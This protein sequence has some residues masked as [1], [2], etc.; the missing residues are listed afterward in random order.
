MSRTALY[1]KYRSRDFDEVVG[2]EYVVRSIRNA[3][4]SGNVGH[5]Y[6]FCGPRGTGKTTMA[7]LLARAVLCENPDR[8]PCG[9][10]PSCLAA[11]AGTHPDIIEINAAN[12]THVED[13]RDLIER[14]RLAPM[15]SHHKVYIIDEVHQL[16]S[17]AAS[18]LLKTLE[19]PPEHVIFIL[20]TTDPQKLI[21]TIISRCQRFDFTRVA[22]EQIK[23]H[24]LYIAGN[25]GFS[26]EE[27]AA[28]KIAELADGG[29]RDA[30]SILEQVSSYAGGE[31]TEEGINRVYGLATAD[32]KLGLLED[33]FTRNMAG[34]LMRLQKYEQGGLDLRKLT[35]DLAAVLKDGV[36]WR[37]TKKDALLRTLTAEQAAALSSKVPAE[38]LLKMADRLLAAQQSYRTGQDVITLL[39]LACME[40]LLWQ[41]P[42]AEA[43]EPANMHAYI[44]AEEPVTAPM[45]EPEHAPQPAVVETPAEAP[46]PAAPIA[47][48][49]PVENAVRE[50][51]VLEIVSLLVQCRKDCK[52]ADQNSLAVRMTGIPADRY[53]AMLRQTEIKASG[54]DCILLG[55]SSDAV[56]RNI[57]E[58][59]FNREF[60][61]W[62]K[63]NGVDRMPFAVTNSTYDEAVQEFVRL[64]KENAL[65]PAMPVVRY[66]KQQEEQKQETL[67]D[68]ARNLFGDMLEIAEGE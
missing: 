28:R 34:V 56:A 52:T 14:A 20:A 35:E 13:I 33:I 8:K 30:L 15:M 67:E 7:R 43:A 50:Y 46:A 4:N 23:D 41:K 61:E 36:I 53:A 27:G 6:L 48:P 47:V 31:I 55:C 5:A 17:S 11:A 58:E 64:R 32:Q 19:E 44:P 10:C 60:Y 9:T 45:K 26:L 68:R 39:E 37:Y 29:M 12:E 51:N 38:I 3:V 16:S 24:L 63:Q 21:N 49:E 40:M 1:Q 57:N 54:D 66:V 2:Q 59:S 22:A 25:E 62:L 65:P 42:A 18:A